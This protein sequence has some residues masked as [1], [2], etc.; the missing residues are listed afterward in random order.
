M[1]SLSYLEFISSVWAVK[2]SVALDTLVKADFCVWASKLI[3]LAGIHTFS[4]IRA[5]LAILPSVTQEPLTD[6]LALLTTVL[7]PVTP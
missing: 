2:V 3:V 4:L 6:T 5:V 7:V 1:F